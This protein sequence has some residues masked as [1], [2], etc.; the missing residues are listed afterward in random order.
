VLVVVL[1]VQNQQKWLATCARL[2]PKRR[3]TLPYDVRC[4]RL[5]GF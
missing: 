1:P 4:K 5:A 2:F 3:V